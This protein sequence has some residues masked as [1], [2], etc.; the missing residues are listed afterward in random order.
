VLVPGP[1]RLTHQNQ[2]GDLSCRED[3][4]GERGLSPLHILSDP[5]WA[6]RRGASVQV[7]EKCWQGPG[8]LW[9]CTVHGSFS[10]TKWA[11]FLTRPD[12]FVRTWVKFTV[13]SRSGHVAGRLAL[14][15]VPPGMSGSSRPTPRGGP[16]P[17]RPYP[18]QLGNPLRSPSRGGEAPRPRAPRW[19]SPRS[20][21]RGQCRLRRRQLSQGSPEIPCPQI[22][23]SV[24]DHR[25]IA[26]IASRCSCSVASARA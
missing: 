22:V 6:A 12:P 17:A 16:L 18:G 20:V 13:V 5:T 3:C 11:T 15:R 24:G 1:R 10:H 25:N 26:V 21:Y 23:L 14:G 9:G 7:R 19:P 4:R 8:L 2:K